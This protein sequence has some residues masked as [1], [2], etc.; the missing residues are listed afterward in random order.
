MSVQSIDRAVLILRCF[1]PRTPTLGI[2]DIARTTGLSTSTV[3]RLLGAMLANRLVRQTADRR[4]AL[5]P[6]L[7]QL[8]RGG[9][10]PTTLRDAAL[11]TMTAL[12]DEVDE[13]VGLHELLP[14]EER[15]VLDQVESHQPLRR[16]YTEFGVP[17][18]LTYGAPGKVMLALL[19]EPRREAILRRP[20]A[21]VT[22]TTITDPDALRAELRRDRARR[23]AFSLAE[24]TPG[25]RTVAAPIFDATGSVTGCLS[26]SGPEV[27]M[28]KTRLNELAPRVRGAAWEVSEILGAT[29]AAVDERLSDGGSRAR[30]R[31]AERR[32]P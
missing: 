7:V 13:T 31:S 16:T 20:I 23:Y 17:I 1:S 14:T 24:R 26:V 12:R 15:A 22:A 9:A 30:A 2:S 11:A 29:V 32:A 19:D 8:V 4:Y 10:A 28:P 6:L 25:I 27:R 21:P 18:P 3:H 5:G